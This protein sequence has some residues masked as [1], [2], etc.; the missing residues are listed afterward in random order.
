MTGRNGIPM[1]S[2]HQDLLARYAG[3]LMLN[4]KPRDRL[5]GLSGAL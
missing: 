3:S 5:V 4:D 2:G 1:V